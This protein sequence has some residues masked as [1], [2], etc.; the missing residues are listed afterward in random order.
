MASCVKGDVSTK[1]MLTQLCFA[2][3]QKAHKLL[4]DYTPE[5]VDAKASI[6]KIS[7][8]DKRHQLEDHIT[9]ELY[10]LDVTNMVLWPHDEL[11]VLGKKVGVLDKAESIQLAWL[12][13]MTLVRDK[14]P[15]TL[16]SNYRI[17][18]GKVS[19]VE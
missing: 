6:R 4:L 8:P 13:A 15:Y 12:I 11:V 2:S 19:T 3:Q 7:G 18:V 16:T 5:E 14:I 1:R 10:I 9:R 17:K